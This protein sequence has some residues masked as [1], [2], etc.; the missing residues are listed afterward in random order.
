MVRSLADR[1]FNLGGD[2]AAEESEAAR[3][4][5]GRP[6]RLLLRRGR[7]RRTL[8]LEGEAPAQAEN[9]TQYFD[10]RTVLLAKCLMSCFSFLLFTKRT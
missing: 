1:T 8:P 5:V 7:R 10:K 6:L 4:L 2:V 9:P 3:F